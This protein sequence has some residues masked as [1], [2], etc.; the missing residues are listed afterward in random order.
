VP[1][2]GKTLSVTS[3]IET[4]QSASSGSDGTDATDRE[5]IYTYING[6]SLTDPSYAYVQLWNA[7]AP[8]RVTS[9]N[10]K[11]Q[12]K[13]SPSM[14]EELLEGYFKASS[15]RR[16]TSIVAVLDEL[17]LM[18]NARQSVI[19]NFFN[20]PALKNSNLIVIAIANTMDLPE[21]AL[22]NKIS[23]R[24]GTHLPQFPVACMHPF[25]YV[26]LYRQSTNTHVYLCRSEQN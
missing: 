17:D 2:T 24:L 25:M 18:F 4:I 14:A 8:L 11:L 7:I 21:R 6:M 5:F 3:V 1:G 10:Q 22:S 26:C 20:W 19:Y 13:V 9:K 16:S 12:K 23:S 15:K